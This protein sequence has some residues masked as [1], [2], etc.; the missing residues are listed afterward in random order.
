MAK[1]KEQVLA[2]AGLTAQQKERIEAWFEAQRRLKKTNDVKMEVE[3]IAQTKEFI[4][5]LV[6]NYE[7]RKA[8]QRAKNEA[9]AAYKGQIETI[10]ALIDSGKEYDF[11]F[12][13]I[14]EAING[15]MREKKNAA[16]RAKIAELE[17]QLV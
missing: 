7:K 14:I 2:T 9:E 10:K 15:A 4:N 16:I 12:E 6:Q 8:R 17:A 3:T 13:D 5:K 1:T 11:N